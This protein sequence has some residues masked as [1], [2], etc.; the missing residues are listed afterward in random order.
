MKR[1]EDWE[2]QFANYIERTRNADFQYGVNDCGLWACGAVQ[3]MTGEDMVPQLRGGRYHSKTGAMRAIGGDLV[4][5]AEAIA[6]QYLLVKVP[7]KLAHRGDVVM[8]KTEQGPA[9]GCVFLDGVQAVAA[10]KDGLQLVPLTDCS[11]AWRIPFA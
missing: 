4:K 8:V 2:L 7:V 3:A 11:I 6:G 10:G 1:K 9:L 5:F